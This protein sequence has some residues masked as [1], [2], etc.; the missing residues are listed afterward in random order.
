MSKAKVERATEPPKDAGTTGLPGEAVAVLRRI[1]EQLD[2]GVPV[3]T[4]QWRKQT[5]AE[6]EGI[7]EVLGGV[8]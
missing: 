5:A 1:A 6:L 2:Y 4:R 7:A 3:L 8:G